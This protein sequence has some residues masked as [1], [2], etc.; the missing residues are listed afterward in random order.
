MDDDEPSNLPPAAIASGASAFQQPGA[1]VASPAPIQPTPTGGSARSIPSGMQPVRSG[2]S[3]RQDSLHHKSPPPPVPAHRTH[4]THNVHPASPTQSNTPGHSFF[5]STPVEEKGN[6]FSSHSIEVGNLQN[7]VRET[8]KSVSSL[9]QERTALSGNVAK[10]EAEI[11][12]LKSALAQAKA[13]YDTESTNM[14]NLETRFKTGSEELKKL[15]EE[16]IHAESELSALREQKSETEQNILRDK[17]EVRELK[18]KLKAS[19]D[20]VATLKETLEKLRK[21]ARQ[22]KGLA[23]VSKKQL[24]TSESDKEKMT[25]SIAE[26]RENSRAIPAV[27]PTVIETAR[28]VPLPDSKGASPA[29]STHSARSMNPFF[30]HTGAARVTSPLQT[31]AV[32]VQESID[33]DPFGMAPRAVEAPQ[34]QAP[35]QAPSFGFDDDFGSAFNPPSSTGPTLQDKGKGRAIE[36]A[37][38]E[39]STG[40]NTDFDAAFADFDKPVPNTANTDTAATRD[41]PASEAP[42]GAPVDGPAHPEGTAEHDTKSTADQVT[43]ITGSAAVGAAIG[44]LAGAGAVALSQ[45]KDVFGMDETH[46][47]HEKSIATPSSMQPYE[48]RQLP[49]ET[50][51]DDAGDEELAPIRDV[52]QD[53]SDSDSDS[54]SETE[55]TNNAADKSEDDT[56]GPFASAEDEVEEPAIGALALDE[57]PKN[58]AAR[59]DSDIQDGSIHTGQSIASN[60]FPGAFPSSS[61]GSRPASSVGEGDENFEDAHTEQHERSASPVQGASVSMFP[62]SGTSTD[63]SNETEPLKSPE[64]AAPEGG[65]VLSTNAS[66]PGS[67]LGFDDAFDNSFKSS[68]P[69]GNDTPAPA[70][71]ADQIPSYSESSAATPAVPAHTESSAPPAETSTRTRQS[72]EFDDFEDLAP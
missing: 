66:K 71:F 23:V 42:A 7:Q 6:Q 28:A 59:T 53:E 40:G 34:P 35:A 18:I 63:T 47:A 19:N 15:R 31:S 17:E 58:D 55:G 8:Q 3:S 65:N 56:A 70:G 61:R 10:T 36:T 1:R 30:A 68:T 45:V 64:G 33:A 32:P 54:D 39:P 16:L 29:A 27:S 41:M 49:E 21:E 67:T 62:A 52:E 51:T 44:A 25:K 72:D 14:T 22:Q 48:S 11:D 13:A 46:D 57:H 60:P 37:I 26:E 43:N 20:E 24:A 9:R 50:D 38:A 12:E 69:A 5:N 2:T 4:S